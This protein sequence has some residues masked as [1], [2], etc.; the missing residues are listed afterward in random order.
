M[1]K[2]TLLSLAIFLVLAGLAAIALRAPERG[3]RK[4]PH[5]GP[6]GVQALKA[7][8]IDELDVSN[9]SGKDQKTTLKK[10]GG[11][12]ML[13]APVHYP[14]DAEGMKTALERLGELRWGEVISEQKT[15]QKDFEVDDEKGT[16]VAVK[17]G[18]KL[19]ADLYFGKS[20]TGYTMT[21]PAGTD[22]IWQALGVQRW[23]FAKDTKGWRD[24]V[25]TDFKRD[26]IESFTIDAG[27]RGK[28]AIKRT[29]AEKEKGTSEKFEVAAS[30]TKIDKLDETVPQAVA[31]SIY[32]LRAADFAEGVQPTESGLDHPT[33]TITTKAG[34]N[35]VTL[36]VGK[37]KDDNYYVKRADKDQVFL[38][39][40]FTMERL[41]KP[42]VDFRDK[43]LSDMK[44]DE[45]VA[46]D[47][48]YGGAQ[49]V[50]E[51]SGTD[52][53]AKKPAALAVDNAKVTPIAQA[54]ANWK[55]AAFAETVDPKATG[56][57]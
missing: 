16:R 55:A 11:K 30:T 13:T 49:L 57:K 52:W 38:V 45:V 23:A 21:R 17:S 56:L 12:W 19:L 28:I 40:K 22:Q 26:E 25:I 5:P 41:A 6:A 44:A 33:Y 32:G 29:P 24:K 53:K 42:P 35:T 27:A 34:G 9:G 3:E 46:L 50:L 2:K 36:L 1:N 31:S 48:S 54:F 51:K 39:A 7:D 37:A 8:Q 15:K 18:G 43:T 20:V 4:G 10:E 47:I 14:A